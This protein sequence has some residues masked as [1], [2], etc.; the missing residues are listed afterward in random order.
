MPAQAATLQINPIRPVLFEH[1][2][3]GA[4]H[5]Q[6][7]MPSRLA[8]DATDLQSRDGSAMVRCRRG[9]VRPDQPL[10]RFNPAPVAATKATVVVCVKFSNLAGVGDVGRGRRG[11]PV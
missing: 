9:S 10:P 11:A 2:H 6:P 3:R 8:I 7:S 1:A 5:R 4:Q